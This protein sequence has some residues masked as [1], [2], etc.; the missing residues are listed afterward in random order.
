MWFLDNSQHYSAV[1]AAETITQHS[2]IHVSWKFYFPHV[3]WDHVGHNL[4]TLPRQ[5]IRMIKEPRDPVHKL[6]ENFQFTPTLL[7][8]PILTS[9]DYPRETGFNG[10]GNGKHAGRRGS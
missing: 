8:C 5:T 6:D 1:V 2:P 7:V 9:C 4:S 3:L 10:N